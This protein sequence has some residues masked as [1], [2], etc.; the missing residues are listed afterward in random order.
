MDND[1]RF[2]RALIREDE[3][4]TI[5]KEER[6]ADF[7]ELSWFCKECKT[8]LNN[9]NLY[10]N[11]AMFDDR[12]FDVFNEKLNCINTEVNKNL[13]CDEPAPFE[14]YVRLKYALRGL[15]KQIVGVYTSFN[16]QSPASSNESNALVECGELQKGQFT[17][18]RTHTTEHLCFLE[19][20]IMDE[21]YGL[22]VD[23]ETNVGYLTN[24]GMKALEVAITLQ[25]LT[26][27]NN[28]PVYYHEGIYFESKELV[29]RFYSNPHQVS[30]EEL[31]DKVEK[32]EK[33]NCIIMDIG[34]NWPVKN[35]VALNVFFDKLEHHKQR[36]PLF[37]IV[38]CTLAPLVS[39]IYLKY[40]NKLPQ[41]VILVTVE[42]LLKYFQMGLE[43]TNLGFVV[44]HGY[45]LKRQLY[46]DIVFD[47]LRTLTAIPDASLIERISD[48]S[49]RH[50]KC[51]LNRFSRNA[52]FLYDY[53]LHLKDMNI[54][55]SV[56]TSI[57]KQNNFVIDNEQ[58]IGSILYVQF[59][60]FNSLEEYEKLA[61]D[62]IYD[63]SRSSLVCYG[64]SFGFDTTRFCAVQDIKLEGSEGLCLRISI[65]KDTILEIVNLIEDFNRYIMRRT[66]NDTRKIG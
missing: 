11:D 54:V 61:K 63:E 51:R 8:Q 60:N 2:I 57:A 43:L 66:D 4:E 26:C 18:M 23:D 44:F 47:L 50:L 41:N 20:K 34:N 24:S 52:R 42:S 32:N 14:E 36:E 27:L 46:R 30:T 49:V 17:Y 25:K 22:N 16:W 28:F 33:I 58:W 13:E 48:F 37:I 9:L 6:I 40:R 55:E 45:L 1:L 7:E 5:E 62:F 53:F 10:K 29:N 15:S 59:K 35:G 39:N 31:Y 56:R 3:E 64:M 65:G 21:Y 38:D 12:V 19:N